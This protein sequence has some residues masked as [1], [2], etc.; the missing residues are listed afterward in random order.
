MIA[1]VLSLTV[2]AVGVQPNLS[3][4][5]DH[6]AFC[7]QMQEAAAQADVRAGAVIDRWTK[8]GGISIDC[9]HRAVDI[10]TLLSRPVT[11]SWLKTEKRHWQDDICSDPAVAEA[12][13]SGWKLT[14]SIMLKGKVIAVFEAKCNSHY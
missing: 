5:F 6:G 13:M 7:H 14:A 8:H 12:T 9:D 2:G 3:S 11:K 4:L 10:R 1:L